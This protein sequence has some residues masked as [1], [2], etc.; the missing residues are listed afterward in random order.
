[1]TVTT[2]YR[3]AAAIRAKREEDGR[4][5]EGRVKRF[6]WRAFLCA[7]PRG[8]PAAE[9][10]AGREEILLPGFYHFSSGKAE[11]YGSI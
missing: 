9:C 11:E 5:T 1:M 8:E 2:E 4:D 3:Q 7:G 6:F 10:A